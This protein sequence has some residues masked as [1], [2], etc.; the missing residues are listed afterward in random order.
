MTEEETRGGLRLEA[1]SQ[2]QLAA[3]VCAGMLANR[4]VATSSTVIV[5]HLGSTELAA[6][7]LATSLANV[8]GY[9]MLVG[10]AGTLQTTA[11]QAFGAGNFA[12]VS[13]SLQRCF[14]LCT[15]MLICVTAAW[16]NAG[17][18]LKALGQEEEVAF[19]AATYLAWLLPGIYCY[20]VVQCLQN[21]LAAQRVTSPTGTGGALLAVVYLPLCWVL[22]R[23]YESLT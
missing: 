8:T 17:Y 23:Q 15:S 12:E 9:S 19:M 7:G 5:G 10:V 6:V 21:W 1:L 4:F 11:G 18:L 3:P 16:L 2:I 20:L 14:L 22:V 13:L